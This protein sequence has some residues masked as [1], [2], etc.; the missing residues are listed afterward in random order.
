MILDYKLHLGIC[1]DVCY[2]EKEE[3]DQTS[4]WFVD[5]CQ[6]WQIIIDCF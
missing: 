6:R 5:H 1:K 3:L 2:T 4:L